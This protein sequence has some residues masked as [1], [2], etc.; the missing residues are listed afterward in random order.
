MKYKYL[1]W[2]RQGVK[3]QDFLKPHTCDT[4]KGIELNS[5][6]PAP[7]QFN[8]HVQPKHISWVSQ[9][10]TNLLEYGVIKKW[11]DCPQSIS[12]PRPHIIHPLQVKEQ[13]DKNRLIYDAQYLNCFM[14]PPSFTM[15]GVSKLPQQGWANMYMTVIDHKNGYFHIGLD[16]NSWT[17]F[18]LCWEDTDYVYTTLCFGWSPSAFIYTT[19]TELIADY[20]RNLTLTLAI[21]WIDDT[22]TTN[23]IH[24]QHKSTQTQLDSANH[25]CCILCMVL[26]KAGYFIN[27]AK[28]ILTPAQKLQFLGLIIDSANC[29]FFVPKPK[30]DKLILLISKILSENMCTLKELEKCV[31]KCRNMAIAVPPAKLYTR[32]Q[33]QT[34]SQNL[35]PLQSPHKARTKLISLTNILRDE[36]NMWLKLDTILLNGSSWLKPEHIYGQL[37]NFDAFSDASGRRWGGHFLV[38]SETFTTAGQ[39]TKTELILHIN[40][41]EGIAL[42][43]SLENF[44]NTHPLLV[45]GKMFIIKIDNET[46]YHIFKQGGSSKQMFL[47]NICKQ[48]FWLEIKFQCKINLTW[49]PSKENKADPSTRV[50]E[51]QDLSL[52]NTSFQTLLHKKGPFHMDLMSS[53]ATVHK[54]TSGNHLPFYS[55]Y[56]E[57]QATSTDVFAQNLTRL[58]TPEDILRGPDYCFPPFKMIGQF[59]SHLL[60]CKGWCIVIVPDIPASWKHILLFG[61]TDKYLISQPY[62]DNTFFGYKQ[63]TLLP[64]KSKFRMVAIELDFRHNKVNT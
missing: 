64:F 49:V 59:L 12:S 27:I 20:T 25:V 8:N 17:F 21:T 24:C 39:F 60:L 29:K 32:A 13:S 19:F 33:Y 50:E 48:I 43:R 15:E 16:K 38:N 9:E 23:S 58:L 62:Q 47:T 3:I 7:K 52:S 28:S 40:N 26:Y 30:V 22:L 46:L 57:A 51:Q 31:G 34:L 5:T 61:Q 14:S 1:R 53:Y 4:Y 63:N 11:K 55:Q 56:Y 2:L 6:L 35:S 36:L 45:K 37:S 44:L 18:G 42:L 41:K 54:D 10:I